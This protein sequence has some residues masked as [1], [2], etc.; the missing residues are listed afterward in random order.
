M[1]R[2]QLQPV[3]SARYILE[4]L[5]ESGREKLAEITGLPMRVIV[6]AWANIFPERQ[7]APPRSDETSV[8]IKLKYLVTNDSACN[9][10]GLNPWCLSEGADGEEEIKIK[11]SDA[12]KWG[13]V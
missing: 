11:L 3:D 5:G 13:F 4:D 2:K 10:L 9:T 6:E 1:N 12:K 8:L 7:T